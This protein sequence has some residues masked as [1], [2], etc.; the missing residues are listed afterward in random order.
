MQNIL[1]RLS[2]QVHPSCLACSR[3]HEGCLGL[4]FSPRND[5]GVEA[6]FCCRPDYQGYDGVV[7]GGVISTVLDSAMTNCLFAHDVIAVTAELNVR[8]RHPVLTNNPAV[9]TAHVFRA[10]PPLF[11]V[12]AKFHQE[13]KIKATAT[14]KFMQKG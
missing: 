10:T 12:E 3:A 11:V 1:D 4:E 8:F 2:H 14:G 9:V 5:G 7:H 6:T 13:G